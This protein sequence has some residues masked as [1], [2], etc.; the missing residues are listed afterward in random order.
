MTGV[1]RLGQDD[2]PCGGDG[3]GGQPPSRAQEPLQQHA[4]GQQHEAAGHW[5]QVAGDGP[6]GQQ[7]PH[8]LGLV[9]VGGQGDLSLGSQ[10]RR[11]MPM[12]RVSAAQVVAAGAGAS[13]VRVARQA[14]RA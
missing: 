1:E 5:Q 10:G 14:R 7:G 13:Q 9:D 3:G 12:M 2:P 11:T 6:G 4:D 8:P